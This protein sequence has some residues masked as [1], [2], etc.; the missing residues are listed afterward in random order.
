MVFLRWLTM[1]FVVVLTVGFCH[2]GD[3]FYEMNQKWDSLEE[4]MN[5]EIEARFDSMDE[6]WVVAQTAFQR[7]W[8]RKNAQILQKWQTAIRST[9]KDW[10]QYTPDLGA[11]S[12]VDFENGRMVFEVVIPETIPDKTSRARKNLKALWQE[13]M[14]EKDMEGQHILKDQLT[15]KDGQSID[16]LNEDE[17]VDQEVLPNLKPSDRVFVPGDGIRRRVYQVQVDL[18]PTHIRIR[19]EKYLPYVSRYAAASDLSPQLVLAII[20]TESFFNPRAVSSCQ[21]IGLMQIIPRFAGRE[22]YHYIYGEDVV[23]DHEYFFDPEKNIQ[24]GCTYFFLLQTRYFKEIT[25]VNKN[26]YVSICGYNWGPTAMRKKITGRYPISEMTDQEVYD[27]LQQETPEETRNYIER[28][29]QRMS[30]YD[31]YFN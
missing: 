2:A 4:K 11:R 23:L 10:V 15:D 25:E 3:L 8:D 17:F 31:P 18:V 30:I 1:I 26:R 29:I 20:H 24:A 28:V 16:A 22:A 13:L 5:K 19:A 21:A 6:K 9:K 27:L 12:R 7:K 14:A